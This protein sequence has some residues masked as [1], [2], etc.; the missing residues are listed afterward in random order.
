LLLIRLSDFLI[1]VEVILRC[2]LHTS[3]LAPINPIQAASHAFARVRK[4]LPETRARRADFG[5]A[6]AG[7]SEP[8]KATPVGSSF[9]FRRPPGELKHN[10]PQQAGGVIL[11]P[12][13]STS[14]WNTHPF[15]SRSEVENI[16]KEPKPPSAP[17][18][19]THI[20]DPDP[21]R[22]VNNPP[23]S[24]LLNLLLRTPT[25]R[26]VSIYAVTFGLN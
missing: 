19:H 1:E 25:P 21:L 14:S 9:A 8:E 23:T 4:R 11:R 12:D 15:C 26:L 24:G 2:I 6:A 7:L 5:Q 10:L 22:R 18:F 20:Q 16:A 17:T 13:T 3:L